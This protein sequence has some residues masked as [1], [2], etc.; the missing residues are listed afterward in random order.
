MTT[1]DEVGRQKMTR[2][3]RRMDRLTTLNTVSVACD[4]QICFNC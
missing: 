4:Y 1:P 3:V 2:Y